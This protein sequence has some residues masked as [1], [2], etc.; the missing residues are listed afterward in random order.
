MLSSV[1]QGVR[2]K[3]TLLKKVF[4]LASFALLYLFDVLRNLFF[5]FKEGYPS[6]GFCGK[7]LRSL[8]FCKR[9]IERG[10][11]RHLIP[12]WSRHA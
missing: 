3:G 11:A 7:A 8:I 12:S 10:R 2:Q 6:H 5:C 9:T 4:L 1:Q